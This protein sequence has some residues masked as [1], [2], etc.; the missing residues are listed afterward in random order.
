MSRVRSSFVNILAGISGS[1][2]SSILAFIVR[3]VFIRVL[4]DTYLGFNGLY[5]NILTVLSLAELGVGSSII[6]LMYKPL[7]ENDG[8]RLVQ[9]VQFYKKVYRVIGLI[10]LLLG[11][12]LIPFLPMVVNLDNTDDLNYT[13]LYLLYLADTVSSYF[14]FAYKRGILVADQKIYI[15]NIYD[16]VITTIMS[17]LQIVALLVFRDFYI[18]IVLKIVKNI[19]LNLVT[20][21]KVDKLYPVINQF[22]DIEPLP[23][24]EKNQVWKNVYAT[25]VR[26]IFNEMMNST[27]TII[28]SIM[29]GIVMVGKYS[30]YAYI[31]SIVYIFFG[32]IFN[33]IQSSVGNLSLSASDEKKNEVFNRLRFVN[34]FFLSFCSSCFLVLVNPFITIWIGQDYTIPFSGVVAIV[35]ML[36]VRQT[37]NCTTIFRLGEGHFRDFHYSPLIAGLLNL[38]VS[39]ILVRY[40]GLVGVFV[41]TMVGFGYQF[42]VIDTIVTYRKILHRPLSEFYINWLQ[43]LLL[44]IGLCVASYYISTLL[45]V[46][47]IY[48]LFL[49]FA[50]IITFNFVALC[51]VYWRN[52]DFQYFVQLVVKFLIKSWRRIS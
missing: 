19:T 43:T 21:I 30:N 4:G 10:I 44:T 28:I 36:F 3:T 45:S 47:A 38:I 15:A 35:G 22:K 20:S 42:I 37:G 6:Y 51:L 39:V 40:M 13:L 12:C 27:D 7:A 34:F 33:P 5:T 14:F 11:L 9:V 24:T 17:T 48:D 8:E 32:G 1:I 23:Q 52:K 26:Q 2:I 46:R 50:V 49:L 41:G 18:Y 16:I 25:S 29:L 31:L